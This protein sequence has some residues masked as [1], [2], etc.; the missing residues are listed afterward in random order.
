MSIS[1]I[2]V[3]FLPPPSS[4]LSLSFVPM[5]S[6]SNIEK[7]SHHRDRMFAC[8]GLSFVFVFFPSFH[9]RK[10]R[11]PSSLLLKIKNG[12]KAFNNMSYVSAWRQ[13]KSG[14]F[15]IFKD[16]KS[17]F[18][19]EQNLMKIYCR[20]IEE[21]INEIFITLPC[22]FLPLNFFAFFIPILATINFH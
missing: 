9:V 12:K 7:C 21:E 17:L 13:F 4:S 18:T 3:L 19:D 2:N 16:R 10:F 1:F 6:L 15:V 5:Q 22:A 20:L 14:G 8:V 11:F